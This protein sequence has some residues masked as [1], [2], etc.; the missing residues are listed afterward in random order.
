MC[1]VSQTN[2]TRSWEENEQNK[3]QELRYR[4]LKWILFGVAETLV[5]FFFV[6][7]VGVDI[8][9]FTL[10]VIDTSRDYAKFFLKTKVTTKKNKTKQNGK[11]FFITY[12]KIIQG[13]SVH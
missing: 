2:I 4:D 8:V 10:L 1:F 5:V 12:P 9:Y 3:K 11:L 6:L 7:C 13:I